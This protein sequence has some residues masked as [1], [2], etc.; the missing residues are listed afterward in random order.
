MRKFILTIAATLMLSAS[1]WS[2]TANSVIIPGKGNI[3][4]EQLNKKIDL[5]MDISRLSVSEL[6]V[7]RN[8]FAARQ[9]YCFMNADLRGIFSATSWYDDIMNKR[10]DYEGTEK[11]L[12]PIT[13]TPAEQAFIAKLLQLRILGLI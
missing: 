6:R 10:F 2:Q 9:G 3:D 8:A 13:Y 7:L 4:V 1:A 12:K 5:S 11:A